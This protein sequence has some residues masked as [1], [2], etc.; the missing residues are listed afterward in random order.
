[1]SPPPPNPRHI[2]KVISKSE[3]AR[4]KWLRLV[5]LEYSTRHGKVHKWD[6]VERAHNGEAASSKEVVVISALIRSAH[7]PLSTL[8]V[9]QWRPPVGQYTIEFPAGL[10]DPGESIEEAALRELKEETGYVPERVLS[11]SSPLPL[12]PGLTDEC[13]RLVTVEVEEA[14][15]LDPKQ[16]LD[17]MEDIEIIKVPIAELGDRLKELSDDG[18]L[19]FSGVHAVAHGL[20]LADKIRKW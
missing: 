4:T 2:Y 1:M 19:V 5:S 14:N 6:A 3:I 7:S 17:P 18:C 8:L 12:S 11:I 20:G 15:N 13:A 16:S 9:K 10:I